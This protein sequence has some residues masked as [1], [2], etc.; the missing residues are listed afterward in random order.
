[1]PILLLAY[2]LTNLFTIAFIWLDVYLWRQW[3]LHKDLLTEHD[4]DYAQRCLIGAIVLVVYLL[5][6]KSIIRLL[7]SKTRLGEDEP[8]AERFEEQQQL[9]RPDGSIINIEHGGVKGKQTL[10]FIHGWNS[11]SMQWY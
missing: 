8:K 6:G 2:C 11:N 10:V 5:I 1:M 7:L 9:S 3:Y 4:H